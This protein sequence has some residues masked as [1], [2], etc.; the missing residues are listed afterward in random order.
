M[1]ARASIH[2]HTH[3][4]INACAQERAPLS[5]ANSQGLRGLRIGGLRIG[6]ATWR[7]RD[8]GPRRGPLSWADSESARKTAQNAPLGSFGDRI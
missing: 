6:A 1:R 2:T 3:T 8:L 4:H 7:F 5:R